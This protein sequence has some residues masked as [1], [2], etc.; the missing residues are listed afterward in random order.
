MIC[1]TLDHCLV[2]THYL[3]CILQIYFGVILWEKRH[4]AQT[5]F[6]FRALEH[7]TLA[8]ATSWADAAAEF[9]GLGWPVFVGASFQPCRSRTQPSNQAGGGRS[10]LLPASWIKQ[11]LAIRSELSTYTMCQFIPFH[12]V[13][14]PSPGGEFMLVSMYTSHLSFQTSAVK[15]PLVCTHTSPLFN[16]NFFSPK[17]EGMSFLFGRTVLHEFIFLVSNSSES[18]CNE[19]IVHK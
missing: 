9:G 2:T 10:G 4:H 8:L 5:H 6:K 14:L 15:P 19:K 1:G 17:S 13:R 16:F 12:D 18:F 3:E 7:S 11:L